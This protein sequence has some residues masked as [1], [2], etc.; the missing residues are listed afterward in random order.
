MLN[1]FT[2]MDK[3]TKKDVLGFMKLHQLIDSLMEKEIE[4]LL[5]EFQL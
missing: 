1:I 5:L 2:Y 3:I 4:V